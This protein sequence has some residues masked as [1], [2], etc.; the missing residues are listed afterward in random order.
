MVLRVLLSVAF[1]LLATEGVARFW[2]N[3]YS[4][5]LQ[6]IYYGDYS[7]QS[8]NKLRI[9]PHPYL[10]YYPTP[11]FS[12]GKTSH[13]SLG[14]RGPE[15]NEKGDRIRIVCLGGS[16][17]YTELVEDNAMT[18]PALLQKNINRQAALGTP[19][20][21]INAGAGGWGA[22]ESLVNLSLRVL[23]LDP[24]Y[25][26]IYHG[27][28]D[29]HARLVKPSS[30]L[31][32][33]TGRRK[34]WFFPEQSFLDSVLYLRILRRRMGW[35]KFPFL[36]SITN[37]PSF[38][39][40]GS[41]YF[42]D[43]KEEVAFYNGLLDQNSTANFK[44][45]LENIVTLAR[46]SNVTPLIATWAYTTELPGY[47]DLEYYQRGIREMNDVTR[48]LAREKDVPILDFAKLMPQDAR[49]WADSRHVNEDGSEKKAQLF[50]EWIMPI[51]KKGR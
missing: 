28:N 12:K 9:S 24:D 2:F 25:I 49:F 36:G 15:I 41:W 39:G 19:V 5:E 7:E 29:V 47:T 38:K 1:V 27:V 11:N 33:N 44:R 3:N 35:S 6:K 20:E 16:T 14:Y 51:L 21:V 18:Y 37:A 4:S 8:L 34:V 45:N 46:A 22:T 42:E 26:V 40:A 17:T 32:D 43:H 50:A 31:S 48:A 13:N 10:S 23:S 30:F